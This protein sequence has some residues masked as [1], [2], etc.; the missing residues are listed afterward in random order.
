MLRE[1]EL[2]DLTTEDFTM[3]HLS[4]RVTLYLKMSKMD[5]EGKGVR[6]TLQCF[7]PR[8]KRCDSECPYARTW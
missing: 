6:R 7:C 4:R 8:G 3:D 1:I 2:A 5:S